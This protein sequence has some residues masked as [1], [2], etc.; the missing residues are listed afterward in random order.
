MSV[1]VTWSA[2]ESRDSQLK[3]Q[4]AKQ[5]DEQLPTVG[6]REYKLLEPGSPEGGLGSKYDAY[7]LYVAYF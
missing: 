1:F 6:K 3:H 5:C 4:F 7:D 2:P